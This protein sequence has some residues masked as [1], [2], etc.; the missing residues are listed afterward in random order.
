MTEEQML[1]VDRI[2]SNL[3]YISNRTNQGMKELIRREKYQK[4]NM[5]WTM[6]GLLFTTGLLLI[7]LLIS[8]GV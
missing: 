5:N 7:I 1:L 6:R 2:D 4:N 8:W 3:E